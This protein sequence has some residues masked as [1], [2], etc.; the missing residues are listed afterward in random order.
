MKQGICLLPLIFGLLSVTKSKAQ[1]T[2]FAGPQVTSA[3]YTIRGAEQ[4][5]E[6]KQGFIAGVRLEAFLEGPVYFSPMLS[7]TKKGYKVSFD[8]PAFP[9]DSGALNNNTSLYTLELAPLVQFNLSKKSSY[10][11]L[12]VG[13]AFDFNLSGKEQFD[14]IGNK[15]IERDMIFSFANYSHA[16]IS[17]NGQLGY[18]HASGFSIFAQYVYGLSSLNNADFGPTIAHRAVGIAIGWRLGKKE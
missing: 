6:F 1:L 12:R 13:P 5:T 17:L 15:R 8:E 11:F 18:Q 3:K 7:F 4:P 2:V 10:L 14:S 16:T 9:P